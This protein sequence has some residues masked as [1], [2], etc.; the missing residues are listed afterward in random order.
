MVKSIYLNLL[1]CCLSHRCVE[2]YKSPLFNKPFLI[3]ALC[4]FALY[5]MGL[6]TQKIAAICKKKSGIIRRKCWFFK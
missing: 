4:E 3:L 1:V 6:G 2:M 5:V